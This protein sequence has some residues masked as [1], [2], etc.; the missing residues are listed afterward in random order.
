MLSEDGRVLLKIGKQ[1]PKT[2]ILKIEFNVAEKGRSRLFVADIL[3]GLAL[4]LIDDELDA[5][6]Y[7]IQIEPS[8]LSSGMYMCVLQTPVGSFGRMIQIRK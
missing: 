5:G 6:A 3:G 1:D 4:S 8:Q 2:G 7:S